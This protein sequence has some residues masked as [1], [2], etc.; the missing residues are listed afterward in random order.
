M[1]KIYL[2]VEQLFLTTVNSIAFFP[3][4]IA[5]L[6]A[7]FAFF[8]MAMEYEPTVMN[9]KSR[10]EYFIIT[11]KDTARVILTTLIGSII[12]LMVFSFSMVMVVLN[13]ASSSFSP[14]VIPGLVSN[15]SHQLVLGM[16]I[17]TII[18]SLI[19]S[20]NLR[21]DGASDI[22]TLG[23]FISMLMGIG[24]LAMF[25]YFIDT[26]SR[27]IQVDQIIQNIFHRTRK[28]VKGQD[29][30]DKEQGLENLPNMD[31]W[32]SISCRQSG[33]YK[34]VSVAKI[35]EILKEK[36]LKVFI[37]I[38]KGFFTVK[39]YPFLLV[40]RDISEEQETINNILDCFTFYIEEY[41][42]DHYMHGFRQISEIATKAL[43]PGINDPGTALKAIDMLSIL[44]SDLVGKPDY[45]CEAE[46]DG[47]VH[48]FM[49]EY[50]FNDMLFEILTPI[51]E[52]GKNDVLVILRLVKA[53]KNIL[54]TCEELNETKK[55]VL[56]FLKS[57]I[58]DAEHNLGNELDRVQ[59]NKMLKS[60]PL[61]NV[62]EDLKKELQLKPV[63]TFSEKR[64]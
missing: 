19:V 49:R 35:L 38:P 43:S 36:N 33:Y 18:F 29:K 63:K 31:D 10:F 48:L 44:F 12:S 4:L 25:I 16:Y 30:R 15:K 1:R 2:R 34:S 64:I 62:N 52:F 13:S 26:I 28:F 14:R 6:F 21:S 51:R 54:Y 17:G 24:C 58:S 42:K 39:G 11:D 32:H 5:V 50:H 27:T 37:R 56:L 61:N 23:V 3:A 41:V 53:C 59:V 22:P 47:K 60:L 55:P 8:I 57:I 40:N 20:I 9:L 7:L 46:K 45:H